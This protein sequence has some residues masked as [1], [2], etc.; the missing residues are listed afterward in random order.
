[1]YKAYINMHILIC[2]YKDT[3]NQI[4]PVNITKKNYLNYLRSKNFKQIYSFKIV[5]DL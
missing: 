3:E 4:N 5:D 2:T 1:M